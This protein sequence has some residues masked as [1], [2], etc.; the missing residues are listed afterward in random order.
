MLWHVRNKRVHLLCVMEVHLPVPG[1]RS[2]ML[3]WNGGL[4]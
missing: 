4:W 1:Q 3:E 2:V